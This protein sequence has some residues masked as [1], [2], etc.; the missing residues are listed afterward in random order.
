MDDWD[1][2]TD[3]ED[4]VY[5][6]HVIG[7][8]LKHNSVTGRWVAYFSKADVT[9]AWEQVLGAPGVVHEDLGPG[10]DQQSLGFRACY[11]FL[12]NSSGLSK[13]NV[14]NRPI[15]LGF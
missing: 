15:V 2:L 1:E 4:R 10:E 3:E 13:K 6:D 9:K 8:A 11:S 14:N 7:L 12:A 5:R